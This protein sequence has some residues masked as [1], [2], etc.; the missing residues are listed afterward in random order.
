MTDL[1]EET[2]DERADVALGGLARLGALAVP[3]HV[4]VFEE[5]FTGLEQALALVNDIPDQRR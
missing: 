2:G 5:V 1:P 3:A 4:G